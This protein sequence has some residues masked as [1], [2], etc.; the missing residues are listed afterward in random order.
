[1]PIII[2][3]I[4]LSAII[5]FLFNRFVRHRFLVRE[6]LSGIDVQLKRRHDLIPN[7][8][9]AVKGYAQYES[10]TLED[11]T[12]IRAI[13]AKATTVKEKFEK[14]N[15]LSGA[16]KSIF[17]LAENYPDLKASKAFLELQKSLTEIEDQIQL[18]RR[19]YNG[20]VRNYNIAVESFP[21]NILAAI[22]NFKPEAFFEIEYATER[23]VPDIKFGS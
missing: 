2:I 9:E 19:Y 3:V 21:N 23:A 12:N 22:L 1:M 20:T 5:I 13:L 7:I 18:A 15:K 6:A 4:P 10:K 17:A 14:E 11:I 8:V 16:F